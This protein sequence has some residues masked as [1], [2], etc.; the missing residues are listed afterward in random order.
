MA[1]L[2]P[3]Q[4]YFSF[5]ASLADGDNTKVDSRLVVACAYRSATGVNYKHDCI[6]DLSELKGSSRLGEPPLQKM[7]KQIEGL[8]KDVHR[9]TTGNGR[10]KVDTY[11]KENRDEERAQIE[12][13]MR[14]MKSNLE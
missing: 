7:A 8:A 10:L 3:N 13:H 1:Y 14:Q 2:G 6:V 11:T 4:E 12:E 9:V 5:W